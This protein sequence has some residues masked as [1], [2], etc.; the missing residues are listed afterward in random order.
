[1]QSSGLTEDDQSWL[2]EAGTLAKRIQEGN[3]LATDLKLEKAGLPCGEAFADCLRCSRHE[4][5]IGMGRPAVGGRRLAGPAADARPAA[6]AGAGGDRRS[7]LPGRRRFHGRTG[8]V[9]A[10]VDRSQGRQEPVR[11]R[12]RRSRLH[13][14]LRAGRLTAR[15][16]RLES[17]GDGCFR[18]SRA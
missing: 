16:E 2:G 15:A 4:V 13:R 17:R 8:T 9:G 14:A 7:G 3:L 6:Q 1:V 5:D 18:T 11:G 12:F 10:S